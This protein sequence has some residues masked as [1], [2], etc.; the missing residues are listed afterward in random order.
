MD[1]LSVLSPEIIFAESKKSGAV[2]HL[3]GLGGAPFE[4]VG[5][6]TS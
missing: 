1:I 5:R 3:F 2:P 6:S 4:S